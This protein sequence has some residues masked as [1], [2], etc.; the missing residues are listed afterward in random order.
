MDGSFQA[1]RG[2][3]GFE[4]LRLTLMDQLLFRFGLDSKR[5]WQFGTPIAA[6]YFARLSPAH[7]GFHPC[8]C[9]ETIDY[10]Y[11]HAADESGHHYGSGSTGSEEFPGTFG[12][13]SGTSLN[14]TRRLRQCTPELFWAEDPVSLCC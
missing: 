13:L 8:A 2:T 7:S 9:A 3:S 4:A 5:K 14:L 10:V 1:V 12:T 6:E 11:G